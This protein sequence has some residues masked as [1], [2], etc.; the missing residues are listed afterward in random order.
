MFARAVHFAAGRLGLAALLALGLTA[1]AQ[2]SIQF[3]RPAN[4]DPTIKANSFMPTSRTSPGAFNAP[5]SL[6]GGGPTA[7]FDVLPSGPS[8]IILNPNAAQWQKT[9]QDRKN[10]TLM[11][12]E[13]ILGV[14]TPESILGL[15]DPQ[16]DPKLTP[17]ERFLRREERQSEMLA[18]NS[19]HQADAMV[20]RTDEA[21]SVFGNPAD[22]S[23]FAQNPD[24]LLPGA[25]VSGPNRGLNSLFSASSRNGANND[26]APDPTWTS[27]FGTPLPLPKPTQEQLAGMDRFRAMMEPPPPPEKTPGLAGYSSSPT[28]APDPFLQPLPAFNPAGSSFKPLENDIGKPTGLTPLAGLSGPPPAPPKPTPLVQPPPWMMPNSPQNPTLPQRQY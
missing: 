8:P 21:G 10:W 23:P 22:S 9:L 28:P 5:S 16:E 26:P 14:P 18:S 11:T 2:Q 17:E 6:F 24:H 25:N 13:Q 19:L 20:W 15:V 12:P 7:N 27:A 4:Q 1:A 3:T